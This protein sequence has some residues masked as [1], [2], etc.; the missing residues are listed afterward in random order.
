[1]ANEFVHLDLQRAERCGFPEV[2]LCQGKTAEQVSIIAQRLAEAHGRFL[3]TRAE[4]DQFAAVKAQVPDAWYNATARMI[5]LDR[6]PQPARPGHVAV[7][8]AGTGDQPVAEEAAL[9]LEAMG[10]QVRRL[11][12]VGVAGLHR[13][14]S[15]LDNLREA[16]VAV[17]VAG[18]DGALPSVV[19]GL[20]SIPVIA[21]PTSI[22]YG[23]SF[24]GLSALLSML[25]A[26]A[27]GIT[28]VNIDNGFGAGYAA[29]TIHRT[30]YGKGAHRDGTAG[31]V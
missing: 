3:A 15:Q 28:V 23:A 11:Y 24:G 22:G 25:N 8:T 26:C 1:M 30:I 19:G 9:T 7:L 13:L 18:M 17:V 31:Q 10:S 27:A 4:P 16:D 29:A 20:V 5:G 12:D 14:L 21:V 6:N 2:V